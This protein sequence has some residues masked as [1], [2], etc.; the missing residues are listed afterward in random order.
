M[1]VQLVIP[2]FS[3]I[4]ASIIFVILLNIFTYNLLISIIL[5]KFI[6]IY[7]LYFINLEL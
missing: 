7:V 6:K 3:N 1:P 2:D 4:N 5:L